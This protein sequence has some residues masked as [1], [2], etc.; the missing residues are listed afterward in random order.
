M[1]TLGFCRIF[2]YSALGAQYACHY[3]LFCGFS[4]HSQIRVSPQAGFASAVSRY[5][6]SLTQRFSNASFINL[7]DPR[8]VRILRLD[9]ISFFS[10]KRSF[11]SIMIIFTLESPIVPGDSVVINEKSK[12]VK[13]AV[14]T[15]TTPNRRQQILTR[16]RKGRVTKATTTKSVSFETD[17][18]GYLT[19]HVYE[20][21]DHDEIDPVELYTQDE[22]VNRCRQDCLRAV[23]TT[24]KYDPEYRKTVVQIFRSRSFQHT[25]DD[26]DMLSGSICRGLERKLSKVFVTHRR[27]VVGGVLNMQDTDNNEECMRFFSKRASQPSVGFSRLMATADRKAAD[28]IY[29]E[30]SDEFFLYSGKYWSDSSR[31]L[32]STDSVDTL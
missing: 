17:S 12:D 4:F 14:N 13:Q 22:D 10:Q 11:S 24:C 29:L 2:P 23:R 26:L 9:C 18:E 31:S 5:D 16:R 20:Y 30:E 32:E 25:E 7:N 21:D 1:S 15:P 6:L 28:E 8:R 3:I 19:S 27:W